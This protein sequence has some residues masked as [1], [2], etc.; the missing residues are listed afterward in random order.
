MIAEWAPAKLNL[1]LHVTGQRADGFHLLDSLV[2]FTEFGDRLTFSPAPEL[3][4]TVAGPLRGGV[5]TGAENLVLCAA[6]LFHPEIGAEIT[7]EKHL[8]HAAGIGGGSADAAATLHGLAA[9]TGYKMPDEAAVLSL[10]ADVPV[11]LHGAPVRMQGIGDILTPVPPLPNSF[12]VLVNPGVAVPTA[13]VFAGLESKS[14]TAMLPPIWHDFESFVLWLSAQRNDLQ[15]SAAAYAPEI[16]ETLVAIDRTG[17]RLARMS[18]SG[19][20]CFG[21][22]A[23][24]EAAADAAAAISKN[25]PHWWVQHTAIYTGD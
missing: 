8:P 23:A 25:H 21:L 11:C 2:V 3:S 12:V 9:L 13:V 14:N 16:S 1:S 5:P 20:T 10:G 15:A 19:A 18:G 24:E 17:A 4:L 7:L 22:F 6:R